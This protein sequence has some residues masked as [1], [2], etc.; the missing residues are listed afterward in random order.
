MRLNNQCCDLQL[1]KPELLEKNGTDS[2]G[3]N[4][5]N[6]I[7]ED[8]EDRDDDFDDESQ[9]SASKDRKTV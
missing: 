8:D 7:L 9:K 6:V 2:L 4:D 1:D 3:K 5:P